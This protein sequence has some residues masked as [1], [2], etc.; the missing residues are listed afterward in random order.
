MRKHFAINMPALRFARN[1]LVFSLL[2]L[3]PV[4]LAYVILTPGFG[5]LLLGG[6]PPLSRFLRQVVTNGLPVAFLLSFAGTSSGLGPEHRIPLCTMTLIMGN[7]WRLD[8]CN[9]VIHKI[10]QRCNNDTCCAK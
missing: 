10:H 2:G 1:A 8:I 6:G 5:T 9:A 4:L 3:I 7:I